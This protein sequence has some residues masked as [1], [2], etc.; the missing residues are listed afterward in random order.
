MG[1]PYRPFWLDLASRE[2][3]PWDP[4]ERCPQCHKIA[5][6]NQADAMLAALRVG[7]YCGIRQWTY[8]CPQHLWAG[9]VRDHRP[10]HITS[11]RPDWR[12]R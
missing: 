10:W 9:A 12:R 3:E 8:R 6:V 11:K 2:S 7:A 1:D 5:Y 4:R